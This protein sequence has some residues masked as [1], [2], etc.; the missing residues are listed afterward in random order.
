MLLKKKN[1]AAT[2]PWLASSASKS[3]SS[4]IKFKP[5]NGTWG[6]GIHEGHTK[7]NCSLCQRFM[8][9]DKETKIY[10]IYKICRDC[11]IRSHITGI[12]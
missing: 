2:V 8:R 9:Y 12:S 4:S 3:P 10:N 1:L 7:Y 5:W 11:P 6:N